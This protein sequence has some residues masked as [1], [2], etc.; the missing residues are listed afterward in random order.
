MARVPTR[1]GAS[2]IAPMPL[3]SRYFTV[4]SQVRGSLRA[5]VAAMISSVNIALKY[6][7]YSSASSS[8]PRVW[9]CGVHS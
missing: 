2:S 3:G 6:F 5:S 4:K 8:W 7:G 9:R 1:I